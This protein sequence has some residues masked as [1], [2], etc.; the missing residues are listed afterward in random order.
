MPVSP[1]AGEP[2]PSD[3][4]GHILWV[5][6]A[7][8]GR[9]RRRVPAGGFVD[10]GEGFAFAIE[11]PRELEL[12]VSELTAGAAYG[13]ATVV[14]IGPTAIVAA[15]AEARR[16]GLARLHRGPN[17]TPRLAAIAMPASYIPESIT[18]Q[19]ARDRFLEDESVTTLVYADSHRRPL[20][21][22]RREQLFRLFSAQYGF[23][24]YAARPVFEAADAAPWTMPADASIVE[25]ANAVANRDT[26]RMSDDVLV[27]DGL[28]RCVGVVRL[29]D[30]LQALTGLGLE[31]A[32]RL[33][34]LT[35]L[36]AGARTEMAM[37]ELIDTG[38]PLVVSRVD[39]ADFKGYNER[40][41]FATGDRTIQALG[42]AVTSVARG[43][44]LR[45]VGHVGGDDFV[46]VTVPERID[47]ICDEVVSRFDA[48]VNELYSV[49]DL[50]R[51]Y[52]GVTNR[53]GEQVR[54][55]LLTITLAVVTSEQCS[56]NHIARISDVASELKSYGKNHEGSIVV[57]E[58]RH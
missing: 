13:T 20:A 17:G 35:G 43:R 39:I 16:Q 9:L 48:A 7:A 12:L 31:T 53:R 29:R 28:D 3:S 56:M 10:D 2:A 1:R 23:A 50:E 30:L 57:K 18:G 49:E 19:A 25:A 34:P 5:A 6:E 54:S 46:F 40:S 24:V 27:V 11:D 42:R 58:R 37:A 41:G 14:G 26:D 36:P 47:A 52:I 21:V 51:G 32:G 55:P 44:G 38:E 4:H 22:L 15:V 33:N 8:L 45:F